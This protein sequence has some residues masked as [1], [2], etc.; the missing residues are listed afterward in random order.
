MRPAPKLMPAIAGAASDAD[1]AGGGGRPEV[2]AG[3]ALRGGPSGGHCLLVLGVLALTA[4]A[5][6]AFGVYP[7]PLVDFA[8]NAGRAVTEIIFG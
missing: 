3:R 5:T 6:I 4:G 7:D 1:V 2:I 8:D